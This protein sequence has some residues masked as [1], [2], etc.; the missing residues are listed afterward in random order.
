QLLPAS[1]QQSG[2]LTKGKLRVL[3]L[4]QSPVGCREVHVGAQSPLGAHPRLLTAVGTPA[5]PA[6]TLVAVLLLLLLVLLITTVIVVAMS[7]PVL[8]GLLLLLPLLHALLLAGT[9][10]VRI[11]TCVVILLFLAARAALLV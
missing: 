8:A 11:V 6:G 3:L 5:A 7:P 4:D 2:D 10:G 1:P 9:I